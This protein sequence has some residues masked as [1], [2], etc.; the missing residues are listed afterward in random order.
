MKAQVRVNYQKKL[1]E[2]INNMIKKDKVG[3]PPS[4]LLHSCC[5]P[6]S[7]YV[8]FYLSKYFKITVFYYNPNIRPFE[9][10]IRR[11][12]EQKLFIKNFNLNLDLKNKINLIEGSYDKDFYEYYKGLESEPERGRRCLVCYYQRL[13]KTA[14]LAREYN[15][16]YFTTTLTISPH[17]D[18]QVIN[19]LGEQLEKKYNIKYLYSDFKKKEGYKKSIE[20]SKK[21]NLYR[22]DY[23]GCIFSKNN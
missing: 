20:L 18:A 16:N 4:L 1:D 12:E 3:S 19:N 21:Y 7:S 8:L 14:C 2:I 9:E 23:C 6:C 10:Y 11:L 13:L 15:Y 17:K 5:A 22:Q